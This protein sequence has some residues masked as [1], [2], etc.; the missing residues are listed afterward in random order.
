MMQDIERVCV[1]PT[2]EDREW[3]PEIAGSGDWLATLKDVWAN[4]RDESF[5]RQFL[6]PHLM[7]KFKFFAL[8]DKADEPRYRV[9]AIHNEEGY[10]S[11]RSAIAE[12]YDLSEIMPD[13]QVVDVDLLGDRCL[14]LRHNMRRG[15]RLADKSRDKVLA[16]VR[17]L[18]G[19]GVRLQEF[20][21]ERG[22]ALDEAGAG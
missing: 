1:A 19:Y 7:R 18:W 22:A 8:E 5:V 6:S 4:Y 17:K 21:A 3:L 10:R 15:I 14:I 11:L 2:A 20:D 13:I 12:S 9:D 16:H